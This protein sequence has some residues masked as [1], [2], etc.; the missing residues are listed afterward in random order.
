MLCELGLQEACLATR[1]VFSAFQIHHGSEG[2]WE[3][4]DSHAFSPDKNIFGEVMAETEKS[5]TWVVAMVMLLIAA[6][7]WAFMAAGYAHHQE[8]WRTGGAEATD[9]PMVPRR[10]GRAAL[11]D[12]F[13]NALQQIPNVF[14][15]VSFSF[16][17]QIWL[18]ILILVLEVLAVIG[19]YQMQRLEE[20]LNGPPGRRRSR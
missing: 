19:G 13:G 15:V 8:G 16:T 2:V 7:G 1:H 9:G 12:F 4:H 11:A 5:V 6:F 18:P 14:A 3:F 10:A 17:N 20:S